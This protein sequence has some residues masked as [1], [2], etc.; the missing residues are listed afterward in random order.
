M[1]ANRKGKAVI[2]QSGLESFQ[3]VEVGPPIKHM[4][5]PKTITRMPPWPRRKSRDDAAPPTPPNAAE[6]SG[7]AAVEPDTKG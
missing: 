2:P 3:V 7:P 6:P 1:R 5:M 4:P